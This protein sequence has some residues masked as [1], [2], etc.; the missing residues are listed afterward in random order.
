MPRLPV[1]SPTPQKTK[2]FKNPKEKKSKEKF[3]WA[4]PGGSRLPVIL[5]TWEAKIGRISV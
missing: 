1:P 3:H 5:A 2:T 4:P